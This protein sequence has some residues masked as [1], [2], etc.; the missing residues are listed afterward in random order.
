MCSY[1]DYFA[2]WHSFIFNPS[3]CS[4]QVI[5]KTLKSLNENVHI[6]KFCDIFKSNYLKHIRIRLNYSVS[7]LVSTCCNCCGYYKYFIGSYFCLDCTIKKYVTSTLRKITK[8][9]RNQKR[10]RFVIKRELVKHAIL[11]NNINNII[12]NYL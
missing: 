7:H 3:P 11:I 12:L 1:C 6:D 8:T 5:N 4:E 2:T 10:K 9:V